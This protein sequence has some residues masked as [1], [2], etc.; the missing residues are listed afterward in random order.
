MILDN[1]IYDSRII[2]NRLLE[3]SENDKHPVVPAQIIKLVYLC[4]GWTLGLYHRSLIIEDVEAWRVGPVIRR[5]HDAVGDGETAVD[6]RLN[7]SPGP[8][9][10]EADEDIIRQVYD[11]YHGLTAVQLSSLTLTRGTP[12]DI[13]WR[14]HGADAV[15]PKDLIEVHFAGLAGLSADKVTMGT[16]DQN[17]DDLSDDG[18]Q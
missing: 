8:V 12:W 13:T 18:D 6:S 11:V 3:L 2:A 9:L 15:I 4:H 1:S 5:L 17:S 14:R 10:T 16:L 7:A